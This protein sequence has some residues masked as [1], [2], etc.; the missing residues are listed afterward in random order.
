[1]LPQD[2]MRANDWPLF[3]K[4][5]FRGG[6]AIFTT[7]FGHDFE[8]FK[9]ERRYRF[10]AATDRGPLEEQDSWFVPFDCF[11][12]DILEGPDMLKQGFGTLVRLFV[13]GADFELRVAHTRP[14]EFDP[15]FRKLVKAG[16][17]IP[18]GTRAGK[19]GNMGVSIGKTGL[20]THLEVVSL[21][22]RSKTLDAILC[23]KSGICEDWQ[24]E[25]E[26]QA[27]A[28]L[29]GFDPGP[30]ISYLTA[31]GYLGGQ[32]GIGRHDACRWDYLENHKYK[33]WYDSSELFNRL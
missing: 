7:P 11:R 25:A 8:T 32:G 1:M 29:K 12:A 4:A 27:L 26:V 30:V 13:D 14:E 17:K 23:S 16:K 6:P 3:S 28:Q 19:V 31:R 21:Q 24:G 15:E 5:K 22:R 20:H 33:T 18:A 10:H 9:A 2:W